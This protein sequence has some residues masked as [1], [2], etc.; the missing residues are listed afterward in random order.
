MSHA[1]A[2]LA[3]G[4]FDSNQIVSRWI[5]R[6]VGATRSG[7]AE[8][9]ATLPLAGGSRGQPPAFSDRECRLV[10]WHAA[11]DRICLVFAPA[12]LESQTADGQPLGARAVALSDGLGV[13]SV[14]KSS[15][16]LLIVQERSEHHVRYPGWYHVCGGMLETQPV[17]DGRIVAPFAWMQTELY[18][19]LT[20]DPAW[21]G[22]MRCLGLVRDLHSMRPELVFETVLTVPTARFAHRCGPEHS[23]LV[24]IDDA[25]DDL[26]RF[27]E[28]HGAR[29]VPSGLACLLM[30]GKR[31]FGIPWYDKALEIF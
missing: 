3:E 31:R 15:D 18:E 5:D 24:L 6:D 26:R 9:S 23:D 10:D 13:S 30:Y 17:G 28:G 1:F 22:T 4:I 8:D 11:D 14:V 2:I 29:M 27:V 20:I 25:A 12:R 19:E 7:A 21:I 16:G